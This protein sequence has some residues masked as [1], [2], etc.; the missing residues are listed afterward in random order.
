SRRWRRPSRAAAPRRP[1]GRRAPR[2]TRSPNPRP[3]PLPELHR[4]T[5]HRV[6]AGAVALHGALHP[7]LHA[8][9]EHPVAHHLQDDRGGVAEVEPVALPGPL[10]VPRVAEPAATDPR[11]LVRGAVGPLGVRD[12]PP[13]ADDEPLALVDE[14]L[15]VRV[16]PAVEAAHLLTECEVADL[17]AADRHEVGVR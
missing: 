11:D 10:E 17:V 5:E 6:V 1:A 4:R 2:P 15:L 8:V 12:L 14:D 13:E 3:S 9:R 7:R 16:L